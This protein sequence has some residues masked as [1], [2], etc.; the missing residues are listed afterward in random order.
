MSQT[1][2]I[3]PSCGSDLTYSDGSSYICPMCAH[4]WTPAEHEAALEAAIIRDANGN[5]LEDGDTVTVIQDLKVGGDTIKQ[6]SQAK[7]LSILEEPVNDHDIEV[8]LDGMG[9]M[10]LKS[11][12]VKK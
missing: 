5:E 11:H 4:E 6:G 7:K 2:P 1:L 8:T 10:Y 9:R 3:C 12:L